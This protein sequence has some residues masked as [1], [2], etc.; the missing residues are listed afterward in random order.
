MDNIKKGTKLI[1]VETD[2]TENACKVVEVNDSKW[3]TVK[4]LEPRW[5]LRQ[6]SLLNRKGT[7]STVSTSAL[8]L[9]EAVDHNGR[10]WA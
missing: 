4:W 3:V 2:G 1:H 7:T 10:F 8:K 9:P 6:D 5:H